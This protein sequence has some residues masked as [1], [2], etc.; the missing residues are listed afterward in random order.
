MRFGKI[1]S[2]VATALALSSFPAFAQQTHGTI[3]GS[4]G[5]PPAVTPP[6]SSTAVPITGGAPSEGTAWLPGTTTGLDKVGD[7]GVST[8]TVKA[9]PCGAA[10]R[11]TD[12]TTTCIGIPDKRASARKTR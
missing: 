6:P 5:S 3:D 2:T 1:T 9:V 8:K 4:T 7:D 11:E 10:A 12:G